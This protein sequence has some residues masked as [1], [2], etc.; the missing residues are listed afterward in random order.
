MLLKRSLI[1]I[2]AILVSLTGCQ[3]TPLPDACYAKPDSGR[4]RA[5]HKRYYFDQQRQECRTFLWGGCE[6]SVPFD[7]LDTCQQQCEPSVTDSL[8]KTETPKTEAAGTGTAQ[9]EGQ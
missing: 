6:G 3:R 5:A 2:G 1:I 8:S 7:T 4:C 9:T